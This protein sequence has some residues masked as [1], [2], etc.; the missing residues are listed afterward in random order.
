[1][2]LFEYLAIAYSLVL[3]FAAMRLIEGLPYAFDP[4][5]RYWVH[6]IF[7]CS[8]LLSCL[9]SFWVFWSFRDVA[10]DFSL[11]LLA[12]MS[13]GVIYF[14]AC[15]LVPR[16]A[17]DVESWREYLLSVRVRY[18]LAVACFVVVAALI[19]FRCR[20][21]GT[22]LVQMSRFAASSGDDPPARD[23]WGR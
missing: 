11:F 1:M 14:I 18:F 10:W 16:N 3:S 9:S 20:R 21:S 6:V 19:S 23:I 5:R 13:P 15:T 17:P 2:T 7:V 4:A 12:L 8:A 22:H